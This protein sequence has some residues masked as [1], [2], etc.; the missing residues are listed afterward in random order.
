[1]RVPKHA[2]AI[3]RY[4]VIP[5][6]C[7]VDVGCR[8]ISSVYFAFS[9]QRTYD[10]GTAKRTEVDILCLFYCRHENHSTHL[11]VCF[12]RS[13]G[14][15]NRSQSPILFYLL[16]GNDPCALRST[17]RASLTGT[18]EYKTLFR[19]VYF[20]LLCPPVPLYSAQF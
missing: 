6:F 12:R 19:I 9:I 10:A 3:I 11:S 2:N 4:F 8:R 5:V 17:Y 20:Y 18:A 1:M 13:C 7:S 16:C 15:V 14:F